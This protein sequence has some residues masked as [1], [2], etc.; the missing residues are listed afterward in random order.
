V[1][2]ALAVSLR[3]YS[4]RKALTKFNNCAGGAGGG[5]PCDLAA[6]AAAF[7]GKSQSGF[8]ALPMV[9]RFLIGWRFGLPDML[10]KVADKEEGN[11][12]S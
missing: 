3:P 7:P 9:F 4:V 5:G 8:P 2:R 1:L 10:E 12:F 6:G 11:R